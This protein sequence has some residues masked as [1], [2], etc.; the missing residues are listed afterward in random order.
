MHLLGNDILQHHGLAGLLAL[1]GSTSVRICRL[2]KEM[3]VAVV[4]AVVTLADFHQGLKDLLLYCV[5]DVAIILY[6]TSAGLK[7]QTV[8]DCLSD[9][10]ACMTI[11]ESPGI[12]SNR[13]QGVNRQR[14]SLCILTA[15]HAHAI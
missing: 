14:Q 13:V 15:C 3:L 9:A 2:C 6:Y 1:L 10:E 4:Y 12:G 5:G 11:C 8:L 7:Y